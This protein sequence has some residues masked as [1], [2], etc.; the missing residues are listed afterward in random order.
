MACFSEALQIWPMMACEASDQASK[1]REAVLVLDSVTDRAP[2]TCLS[3][4]GTEAATILM[5]GLGQGI[6]GLGCQKNVEQER[7]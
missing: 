1:G 2:W 7:K 5:L 6:V 4:P 3:G